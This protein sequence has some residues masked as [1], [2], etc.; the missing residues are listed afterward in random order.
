MP[1]EGEVQINKRIFS[2]NCALALITSAHT[3]GDE[4]VAFADLTRITSG[5]LAPKTITPADVTDANPAV[6]TE[7]E[8][9]LTSGSQAG[10]TGHVLY[11]ATD[12]EIIS[13]KIYDSPITIDSADSN[14]NPLRVNIGATGS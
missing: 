1:N 4:G 14:T 5:D 10:I 13:L 12:S 11:D 6:I 2:S 3:Q 9:N 7:Q 8:F